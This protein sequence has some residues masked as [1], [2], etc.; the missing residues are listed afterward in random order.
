MS[1][2]VIAGYLNEM[3]NIDKEVDRLKLIN[4]DLVTKRK[5][6]VEEI[7]KCMVATGETGVKCGDT[8]ITLDQ[9]EKRLRRKDKDRVTLSCEVLKKYGC[10]DPEKAL[11]DMKIA[12]K[13]DFVSNDV[14]NIKKNT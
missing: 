14:V 13:G 9:N 7:K 1:L 12:V 3:E 4:S 6:C 8:I 10:S 11:N 5:K 2:S